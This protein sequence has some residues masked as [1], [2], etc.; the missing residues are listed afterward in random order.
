MVSST[1]F[2]TLSIAHQLCNFFQIHPTK[3]E[4][5]GDETD[6]SAVI[7]DRSRRV[8]YRTPFATSKHNIY[9]DSL[10]KSCATLHI[11]PKPS[12]VVRGPPSVVAGEDSIAKGPQLPP[13]L[14]TYIER[15]EEYIDQLEKESQYC[16]VSTQWSNYSFP[17]FS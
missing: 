13:E 12:S 15:Q 3:A 10:P 1:Y 16:R 6:G 9:T 4:D 11:P 17:E 5:S 14:M 2:F 7:S 8:S